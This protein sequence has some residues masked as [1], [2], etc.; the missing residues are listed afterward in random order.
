MV[1]EGKKIFRI[2]RPGRIFGQKNKIQKP[3]FR[4]YARAYFRKIPVL[5]VTHRSYNS[6]QQSYD[7]KNHGPAISIQR[8]KGRKKSSPSKFLRHFVILVEGGL[9]DIN[10]QVLKANILG[11]GFCHNWEYSWNSI[12][13]TPLIRFSQHKQ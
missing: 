12:E 2:K 10:V 13:G 3:I 1:S 9:E 7:E 4:K 8:E 6:T 5:L 11:H